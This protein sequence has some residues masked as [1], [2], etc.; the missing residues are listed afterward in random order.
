MRHN[1][2]INLEG[3]VGWWHVVFKKKRIFGKTWRS[4]NLLKSP[5]KE[6]RVFS[7]LGSEDSKSDWQFM[8]KFYKPQRKRQ[9]G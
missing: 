2:N 8:R 3:T 9:K 1:F 5:T 7:I 6:G 4:L